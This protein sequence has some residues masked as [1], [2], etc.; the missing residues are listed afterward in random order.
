MDLF[1]LCYYHNRDEI[2]AF[3]NLTALF[4]EQLDYGCQY[5]ICLSHC[6]FLFCH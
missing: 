1:L 5:L 2:C 4:V 6:I 3:A